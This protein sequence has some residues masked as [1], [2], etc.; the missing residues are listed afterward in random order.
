[1]IATKTIAISVDNYN[2]LKKYGFAGQSL[3]KAVEKLLAIAEG[4]DWLL[5]Q[6]FKTLISYQMREL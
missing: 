2:R 6:S 3:N 4:A 5:I 1:M